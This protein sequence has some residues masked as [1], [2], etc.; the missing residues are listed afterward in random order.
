M[1][2]LCDCSTYVGT[3]SGISIAFTCG[4]LFGTLFSVWSSCQLVHI[5]SPLHYAFNILIQLHHNEHTKKEAFSWLGFPTRTVMG[6]SLPPCTRTWFIGQYMCN[7]FC[8][9]MRWLCATRQ[10]DVS[11]VSQVNV[12]LAC[13]WFIVLKQTKIIHFDPHAHL[14]LICLLVLRAIFFFLESTNVN[15]FLS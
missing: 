2:K 5:Y 9:L 14:H 6:R 10:T 3:H 1:V 12:K 15:S 4:P 8:D 7:A 11:V 13:T